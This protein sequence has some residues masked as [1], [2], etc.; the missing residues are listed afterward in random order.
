MAGS[1][2]AAV[3]TPPDPLAAAFPAWL[4]RAY[5][6]L[7]DASPDAYTTTRYVSPDGSDTAAGTRA[8]PWRTLL[9]GVESM[10]ASAGNFRLRLKRGGVW[11]EFFEREVAN[12]SRIKIDGYGSGSD[13]VWTAWTKQYPVGHNWVDD[14]DGAWSTFDSQEIGWVRSSTSPMDHKLLFR[15]VDNAGQVAAA[16]DRAWHWSGNRL[17]IR[18][19]VPPAQL[20][21]EACPRAAPSSTITGSL[22]L[23]NCDD[24]VMRGFVID[25]LGMRSGD[26]SKYP[27]QLLSE[28]G[29]FPR[30]LVD[31]C[32]IRWGG[33]HNLGFIAGNVNNANFAAMARGCRCDYNH[34]SATGTTNFVSYADGG[35]QE[36]IFDANRVR[37][38]ELPS[39]SGVTRGNS[40]GVAFHTHAGGSP[41]GKAGLHLVARNTI[42]AGEQGVS[43][44]FSHANMPGD[45]D[46]ITTAAKRAAV[47]CYYVS[48]T[49]DCQTNLATQAKICNLQL[50]RSVCI[51]QR[52][53]I[54]ARAS[55]R[56]SFHLAEEGYT[57]LWLGGTIDIDF[58][59]A[60]DANSSAYTA[61][62][63]YI[64]NAFLGTRILGRNLPAGK[65]FRW[66]DG[67]RS[68]KQPNRE[69]MVNGVYGKVSGTGTM[70]LGMGCSNTTN[71]G[72][73]FASIAFFG[74]PLSDP[75]DPSGFY[76]SGR[77][78]VANAMEL[79]GV[80]DLDEA[81]RPGGPLYGAGASAGVLA[82]IDGP[83][84][85]QRGGKPIDPNAGPSI[86]WWDSYTAPA[87]PAARRPVSLVI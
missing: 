74:V 52:L 31:D 62:A 84:G 55:G 60:T 8:A 71:P 33:Y 24:V 53:L 86:G 54:G 58:S 13:P 1:I 4:E 7:D 69:I 57:C 32:T 5:A 65:M 80:P 61:T 37:Y 40:S 25:G 67:N 49:V 73:R 43:K 21:L 59:L 83:Y 2:L 41:S 34:R 29:D 45:V 6:A 44:D 82:A 19:E 75:A 14:G 3:G 79:A 68:A 16:P 47:R 63:G 48:N 18:C 46:W 22:L 27:V 26:S 64:V 66:N 87:S 23:R 15:R 10:A 36:A 20:S 42:I 30:W 78:G 77:A 35:G 51:D 38:G 76:G 70:L 17:K 39:A 56:I 9:K 12:K 11:R 28:R 72:E 50:G 85:H 81:A